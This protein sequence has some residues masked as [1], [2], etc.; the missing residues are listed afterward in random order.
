[1]KLKLVIAVTLFVTVPV[2]AFA[3]KESPTT[4]APK[5]TIADAQKLIQT[6]SGDKAKL[7]AYCDI[8][9]LQE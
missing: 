7:K 4:R 8:G 3:Q 6:I 2:I 5:P 9:K 1:M